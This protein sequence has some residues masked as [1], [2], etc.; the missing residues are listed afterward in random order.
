MKNNIIQLG[1]SRFHNTNRRPQISHLHHLGKCLRFPRMWQR[2]SGNA[3]T[4]TRN[5]AQ[6]SLCE[7]LF[8]RPLH[9]G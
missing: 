4:K 3:H 6:P 5:T 2:K 1:K 8:A 9:L 7:I